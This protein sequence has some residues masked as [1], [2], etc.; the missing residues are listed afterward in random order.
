MP[1]RRFVSIVV[2]VLC[3][4]CLAAQDAAARAQ[5]AA[6]SNQT[7]GGT[8]FGRVLDDSTLTPPP[9]A[10]VAVDA[11]DTTGTVVSSAWTG[12]DGSQRRLSGLPAGTYKVG[13]APV[14]IT[15]LLPQFYNHKISLAAA[16]PVTVTNGGY[17]D[18]G[19]TIP[20]HRPQFGMATTFQAGHSPAGIAVG[21]FN[22][23]GLADVAVTNIESNTVSILLGK[24]DGTFKTA[25][26][27]PSARPCG[28]AL[29]DFNRDG[30]LDWRRPTTD[31]T[32]TVLFGKGDG[33]FQTPGET[34]Q[35]GSSPAGIAVADLNGD[36]K[37]DIVTADTGSSTVS[38]LDGDGDGTFQSA[39][40]Y[41]TDA[42]P[43]SVAAA[44]LFGHANPYP[45]AFRTRQQRGRR[46]AQQPF[47]PGRV[48]IRQPTSHRR[49]RLGLGGRLRPVRD[50]QQL[51]SAVHR[52]EHERSQRAAAERRQ[53]PRNARHLP[54]GRRPV[55]G[56]GRGLQPGRVSG[57][58]DRQ[59]SRWGSH[60]P[61]RQSATER[62]IPR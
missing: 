35:V 34:Y 23:D 17:S 57:R 16:D 3:A 14:P 38:V 6:V 56:R 27:P 41:A 47:E 42:G 4:G 44:K 58:R 2:L 8:I 62:S 10:D 12:S 59:P 21:D 31:G 7:A 50:R 61:V 40:A 30:K 51:V 1:K 11:Y 33:T 28:I 37:L 43:V 60:H 54:D 29:G 13:F 25:G 20:S 19:Y 32:V 49:V 52:L 22:H 15:E 55:S 26:P 5:S 24:G 36:G 46:D 9:A 39:V 48:R 45:R 53:I 18:T